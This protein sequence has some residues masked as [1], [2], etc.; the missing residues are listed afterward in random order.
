MI[1]VVIIKEEEMKTRISVVS[2]LVLIGGVLCVWFD[3]SGATARANPIPPS[4][5]HSVVLSSIGQSGQSNI[6]VGTKKCRACHPKQ[7]KGWKKS[8]KFTSL[9]ALLPGHYS[10]LKTKNNLD[11]DKDYTQDTKCLKCHTTGFGQKGGYFIPDPS[12]KK[13]V[14]KAKRL[15]NVGCESCHGAG[16]EYVKLH[17]ELLMSKRMYTLDEMYAA[18]MN[19]IEESVC[20]QCHNPDNPTFDASK[21]FNFEERKEKGAHDHYPLRQ[22]RD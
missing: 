22:R 16:G 21:P 1:S 6:F 3:R 12:D 18:G 4:A 2:I 11:P 17:K 5:S 19:K 8:K 9:N 7:H 13:A 20:L 15:A 10:E 14:K